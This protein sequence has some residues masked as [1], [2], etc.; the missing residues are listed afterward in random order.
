[1][2]KASKIELFGNFDISEYFF[3]CTIEEGHSVNA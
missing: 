3:N 2:L 1:M